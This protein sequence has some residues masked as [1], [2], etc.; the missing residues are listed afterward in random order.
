MKKIL[1]ATDFSKA[2]RNA[3]NHAAQLA[4]KSGSELIL[5]HVYRPPVLATEGHIVMPGL[6]NLRKEGLRRLRNIARTLK[7]SH[8]KGL[9]VGCGIR[10]GFAASEIESY[11]TEKKADLVVMGMESLNGMTENI[12]GN[13]ASS[14]LKKTTL[15]A[16]IVPNGCKPE[17]IKKMIFATDYGNIPSFAT[18]D[19]LVDLITLWKAK[20]LVYHL[21]NSTQRKSPGELFAGLTIEH[22]LKGTDHSFFE[23]DGN[24]LT[25]S[26]KEYAL[27]QKANVIALMPREHGFVENILHRS[28]T[29][30]MAF[31]TNIPLLTIP[32][33]TLN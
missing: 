12:R 2:S 25:Q 29:R 24:N 3:I 16:L 9:K 4:K 6:D 32:A 27:S 28:N 26:V 22:V 30:K 21:N 23:S 17:P 5:F 7:V 33:K 8:G 20:I 15:P 1:A 18:L 13:V 31:H 14:F 11:A 10:C 19:P